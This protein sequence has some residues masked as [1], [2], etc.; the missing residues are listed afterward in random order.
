MLD[1]G[2]SQTQERKNALLSLFNKNTPLHSSKT[3]LRSE[4]GS[5]LAEKFTLPES[6]AAS[7]R[8]GTRS[9]IGSSQWMLA[10]GATGGKGSMAGV[11]IR[12]A[13]VDK[14]VLLSYLD[15]VLREG[16]K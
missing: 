7:P 2:A 8:G 6:I 15:G 10:D 13:P 11:P 1:R 14:G 16:R 5:P 12:A 3:P 4:F 9:R